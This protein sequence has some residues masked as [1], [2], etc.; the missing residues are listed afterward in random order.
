VQRVVANYWIYQLRMGQAT[1]TLDAV[2]AG[3]WPVYT[4]GADKS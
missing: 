3:D 1:P 2:A 4:P